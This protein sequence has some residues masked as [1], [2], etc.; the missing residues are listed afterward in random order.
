L[1]ET[2]RGQLHDI[3]A[4]KL[5]IEKLNDELRQQIGRRTAHILAALSNSE[6]L[7]TAVRLEPGTLVEGRYRVIGAIG[8]GGMG[9]VY[10]VERVSDGVRLA[11]KV[12]QEARGLALARLAR[13]A[14]IATKI[15][16]PNVVAIVD[17]DVAQSG[18]VYLVMELV[19]GSS[20]AECTGREPAFYL[21]VL[22]KVLEGLRALHAQNII[23]RDLKPANVLLSGNLE[24][25]PV[26][27]ITDFGISRV[28]SSQ[29]TPGGPTPIRAT[30]ELTS[31]LGAPSYDGTATGLLPGR[32]VPPAAGSEL[33]RAGQILGTPAYVAPELAVGGPLAPAVDVFSLGVLAHQLLTGRRPFAEPPLLVRL[34]G[35]EDEPHEPLRRRYTGLPEKAAE[36]IDACLAHRPEERP[37]TSELL[38]VFRDAKAQLESQMRSAAS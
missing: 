20:L 16:H 31:R 15:H 6:E 12:A 17:A 10:E 32:S 9:S 2:L 3:E 7:S 23:H 4:R 13:E 1:N 35:R 14:Q 38:E 19:R 8:E 22:I 21:D 36:A 37:S 28:V 24:H 33:T 25:D 18:Y 30:D 5:D 29:R 27:K 11:L 26:V 34:A